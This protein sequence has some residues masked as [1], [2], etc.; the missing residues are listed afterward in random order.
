MG[1]SKSNGQKITITIKNDK[2]KIEFKYHPTG[3]RLRYMRRS[4][5]WR[6]CLMIN[7]VIIGKARVQG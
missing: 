7:L 6:K 2:G 4:R 1:V 5:T 3:L